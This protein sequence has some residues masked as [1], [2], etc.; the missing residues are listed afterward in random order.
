MTYP[1]DLHDSLAK[2]EASRERR[3]HETYPGLSPQDRDLVLRNFHPDYLADTFRELR[4]GPN[5]GDRTP[6]ELAEALEAPSIIIGKRSD[7]FPGAGCDLRCVGDWRGWGGR[8]RGFARPGQ[9]G[10]CLAGHQAALRRRQY[11]DGPGRHPGRR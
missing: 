2:V 7:P 10:G 3:M 5:K 1:S 6:R 4:V 11:D 9:R 8:Q